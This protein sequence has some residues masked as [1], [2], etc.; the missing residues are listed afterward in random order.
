MSVNF[1][2]LIL[3]FDS[4]KHWQHLRWCSSP[5]H[6]GLFLLSY[7]DEGAHFGA[8]QGILDL[9]LSFVKGIFFHGAVFYSCGA[10]GAKLMC[11]SIISIFKISRIEFLEVVRA[12][13]VLV[14]LAH[15]V[16]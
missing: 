14:V 3:M 8:R 5:D 7:Q 10:I 2:M 13:L 11:N 9:A 6:G 12:L 4:S 1:Y 16:E 15:L